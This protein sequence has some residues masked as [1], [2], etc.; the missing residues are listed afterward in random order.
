MEKHLS[1]TKVKRNIFY[2]NIIST[3]L[4]GYILAIPVM[5]DYVQRNIGTEGS[6][7]FIALAGSITTISLVLFIGAIS[8]LT[9]RKLAMQLGLLARICCWCLFLIAPNHIGFIIA[10][11]LSSIGVALC[12]PSTCLYETMAA[13]E[14]LNDYVK[15][16]QNMQAYP[17]YFLMLALPIVGIL[18]EINPLWPFILNVIITAVALFA[19]TLYTE[20]PRQKTEHRKISILLNDTL[21]LFKKWPKLRY[22]VSYISLMQA[23]AGMIIFV[24]QAFYLS[25]SESLALFSSLLMIIYLVRAVGAQ[26]AKSYLKRWGTVKTLKIIGFVSSVGL[27]LAGL[28]IDIVLFTLGFVIFMFVRGTQGPVMN[29]ALNEIIT[30]DKRATIHASSSLVKAILLIAF[31]AY[32]GFGITLIG[33]QATLISF[34]IMIILIALPLLWLSEK[35]KLRQIAEQEFQCK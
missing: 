20:A 25:F 6:Y 8:D 12:Q 13:G 21:R 10:F 35:Q 14:H 30:S 3:S 5:V 32:A 33:E 16:E 17:Q 4:Y 24:F 26:R 23:L 7:F 28:T 34:G 27:I 18:Y 22:L 19:A 11:V 29:I 9:S 15:H 2:L 1:S 31:N